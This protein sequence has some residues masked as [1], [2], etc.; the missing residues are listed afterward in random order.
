MPK[1]RTWIAIT[2]IAVCG[3]AALID[4]KPG[5]A[6]RSWLILAPL[7]VT[8]TAP[9]EAAELGAFE[10]DALVSQGGETGANPAE[11]QVIDLAGQ[12]YAWQRLKSS[13]DNVDLGKPYGEKPAIAYAFAT[14]ELAAPADAL[15]GLGSDDAVKVWLNGRLV[16]RNW[17]ER[18]VRLDDD[19]LRLHLNKGIN[20]LL[21]K[22]QNR[23]GG[24]GFSF[25]AI[26]PARLQE[27]L[28][29]MVLARDL[30]GLR[31]A[32]PLAGGADNGGKYGLTAWQWATVRGHRHMM[33]ILEASGI[34]GSAPAGDPGL[35]VDAMFRDYVHPGEP[36]ASVLIARSGKILF[37]KGYGLADVEHSRP[38]TPATCFHLASINK[39]FTAAAILKLQEEGRLRIDDPLSKYIPDY[40]RGDLITLRHLLTH[41][42]GIPDRLGGPG[43]LP[44]FFTPPNRD[45]VIAAFKYLSLDFEPG[46]RYAYSNPNYYLLGTIVEML[47]G[48]A[49]PDFL[50]DRFLLPLRMSHTGVFRPGEAGKAEPY[51]YGDG[52]I[53][54]R[55]HMVEKRSPFLHG[56]HAL[57]DTTAQDLYRWTDAYFNGRILRKATVEA[58]L[59]PADN[60]RSVNTP[61]R[62]GGYGFGWGIGRLR[63]MRAIFHTGGGEGYC[64]ALFHFPE[65]GFTVIIL[66]NAGAPLPTYDVERTARTI[67][68]LYLHD[69][70]EPNDSP[71][72]DTQV[73]P[74][75]YDA[76]TGLY[77]M[78]SYGVM[79]VTRSGSHLYEQTT[80]HG[81]VELFPHDRSRFFEDW[82]VV[83]AG[84]E[85]VRNAAAEVSHLVFS[86]D[87]DAFR[88]PRLLDP[89]R[90]LLTSYAGQ[91]RLSNGQTIEIVPDGNLLFV[92][93]NGQ[94]RMQLYPRSAK[95][96]YL[97][98]AKVTAE[99]LEEPN[100]SVNRLILIQDG[101]SVEGRRLEAQA[102][103]DSAPVVPAGPGAPPPFQPE[104]KTAAPLQVVVIPMRGAYA[105]TGIA[106]ELL[107]AFLAS[108]GVAPVGAPFGRYYDA[109]GTVPDAELRWEVGLPVAGPV[110]ADSPFEMRKLEDSNIAVVEVPGEHSATKPWPRL[111]AWIAEQ[112]YRPAG[113]NVEFWLDGPRTELRIA[114]ERAK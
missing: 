44:G 79:Q 50:R 2:A 39:P 81:R 9:N 19:I 28:A 75:T 77:D 106:L 16:H 109:A 78:G 22:V 34:H 55:Q 85:F 76:F 5:A 61:A 24:W 69:E 47:S 38:I 92:R 3:I 53:E 23:G 51:W 98:E 26:D 107:T 70:L 54:Q 91:Y 112:G 64:G 114:V 110:V 104:I 17:T 27:R 67:A 49:Y 111:L 13:S 68:E 113:P 18:A 105:Q 60:G 35:V 83:D 72:V 90:A 30:D 108:R 87:G 43:Q 57:L 6:I 58:A 37:E 8:E 29:E 31:T 66:A 15:F 48:Q 94:P 62:Q 41:T 95:L 45:Y 42:S 82:K 20:R 1:G 40:P 32:A 86:L 11:G 21:L 14:I 99:F 74:A 59:T 4:L 84:V 101:R 65:A 80:N 36:G 63:G 71:A 89:P 100:G 102:T 88:A 97:L 46:S 25:R 73:D 103:S 7:P 33:K 93:V 96:F 10:R 12:K 52:R 56:G